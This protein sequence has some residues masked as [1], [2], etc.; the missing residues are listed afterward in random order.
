MIIVRYITREVFTTL[1]AVILVL[2]LALLCQQSVRYLNY[3][4]M[5]KIP[6]S[7]LLELVSFEIPYLLA[8]LLPLGLYLGILLSY[9]RLYS[10]Q[11]MPILQ[12]CGFGSRQLTILTMAIGMIVAA[13]ITALMLWV[14]PAISAKRQEVMASDEATL[15]LIQTLIPGRFQVSPDGRHV[16]YVEKISRDHLK[17]RQIFMAQEK[18]LPNQQT[19]NLLAA[20]EGY[21]TTEEHTNEQLFVSK[22]GYR[23]EGVPG[24]NDYRIIKFDKYIVRIPH[25]NVH[26]AHDEVEALSTSELWQD[27]R[28]KAAAEFQWRF[29]IGL[30]AFLL[31]VLAVPLSKIKP[32]QGRFLVLLPAMLLYVVYINL[33]FISRRLVEQGSVSV[34]IGMWWVHLLPIAALLVMSLFA[35]RKRMKYS[36]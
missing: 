33:M 14:N 15:H 1:A 13:V 28:A 19:W 16:M 2:M 23:Y 9:G 32:R 22:D 29:S 11:E 8:L 30:S 25:V 31:A 10:D 21:Q 27:Y 4:A 17:A 26:S 6:T 3:V 36:R 24:Q 20:G 35:L 7:I 12:M 18:K 5:G 34:I